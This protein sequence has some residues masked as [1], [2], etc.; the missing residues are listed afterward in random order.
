MNWIS[1]K[2]RLPEKKGNYLLCW[3]SDNISIGKFIKSE[4]CRWEITSDS[5]LFGLQKFITLCKLKNPKI[6]HWMEL[7]KLPNGRKLNG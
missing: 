3:H 6:T 7:P 5:P 4:K 1:V 2:D